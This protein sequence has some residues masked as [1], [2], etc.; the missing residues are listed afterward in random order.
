MTKEQCV[1]ERNSLEMIKHPE[2][3]PSRFLALKKYNPNT[4]NPIKYSHARITE[5]L[6]LFKFKDDSPFELEDYVREFSCAEDIIEA[7]WEVD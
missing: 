4:K 5:G 2:W 1:R 7:G 6:K 3:W